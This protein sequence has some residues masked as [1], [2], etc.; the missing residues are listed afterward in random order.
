MDRGKTTRKR[1][2]LTF[3]KLTS[4]QIEAFEREYYERYNSGIPQWQQNYYK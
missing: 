2:R 4:A 1:T 3:A